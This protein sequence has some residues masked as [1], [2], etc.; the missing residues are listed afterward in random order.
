MFCPKCGQPDQAAEAFCRRC[1]TFLPDL[2]KP[3]KR[4]TPATHI[5]ANAFLSGLTIATSFTLAALLYIFLGF[6]PDT[7]VLVYV[8]AGF[9]IAIGAWHIQTLIRTLMLRK[10]LKNWGRLTD[11]TEDNESA[12]S[13][14]GALN[15]P[16]F[17]DVVPASVIDATTRD[18]AG[19]RK[20]SPKS[21]K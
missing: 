21:E 11:R 13:S 6:R 8:T 19:S 14:A 1:G 17:S 10:Q 7:P 18:L 3:A 12:S 4:H 5:A 16:D 20:A 9:L 15:A 2:S